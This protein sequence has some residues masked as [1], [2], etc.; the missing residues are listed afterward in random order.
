MDEHMMLIE[1]KWIIRFGPHWSRLNKYQSIEYQTN[2]S[3]SLVWKCIS[4]RIRIKQKFKV[5]KK[6]KFDVFKCANLTA[7]IYHLAIVY[8]IN[9]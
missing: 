7:P 4:N 1:L 2:P 9:I 5:K 8:G 3:N 6:S